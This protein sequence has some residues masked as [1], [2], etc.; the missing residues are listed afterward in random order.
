M[1][2]LLIALLLTAP[3]VFGEPARFI[4]DDDEFLEKVTVA[5]ARLLQEGK[6]K[7]V[8]SLRGQVRAK[9]FAVRVPPASRQKLAPP[10]LYERLRQ[11]T[12]ADLCENALE[13]AGRG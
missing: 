2:T 7:S 4:I 8:E 3:N 1:A 10:E 11:S 9:G 12:L 6:L 5:S 13:R